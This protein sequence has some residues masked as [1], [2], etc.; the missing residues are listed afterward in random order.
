[1]GSPGID[2]YGIAY[3]KVRFIPILKLY[4]SPI[5]EIFDLNYRICTI[6]RGALLARKIIISNT[7]TQKPTKIMNKRVVRNCPLFLY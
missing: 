6:C 5:L 2:L 3:V 4:A 1:M 7:F